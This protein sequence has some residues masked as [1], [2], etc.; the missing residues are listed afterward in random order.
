MLFTQRVVVAVKGTAIE[1]TNTKMYIT[2]PKCNKRQP[3]SKFGFRMMA[4][5][6]VRNQS[7]CIKCRNK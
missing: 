2:C 5:G 3:I 4:N 6:E 1:V 7:W